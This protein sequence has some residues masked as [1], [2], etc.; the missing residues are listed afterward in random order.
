MD[1]SHSFPKPQLVY[2]SFI[3][4]TGF[5]IMKKSENLHVPFGYHC[6]NT[7]L[8]V[9]VMYVVYMMILEAGDLEYFSLWVNHM[10]PGV[11]PASFFG[12]STRISY[13]FPGSRNSSIP[14][15]KILSC[16]KATNAKE[17]PS[18]IQLLSLSSSTYWIDYTPVIQNNL[19][20]PMPSYSQ[21]GFHLKLILF[22]WHIYRFWRL[23]SVK[24][25]GTSYW[26]ELV[27]NYR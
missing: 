2:S 26:W 18:L 12:V 14:G 23:G 15:K 5:V 17:S 4:L 1:R 9:E 8:V 27:E 10:M 6:C 22:D 19:Q 21:L 11:L 7:S 20:A 24:R 3:N 13:I 25:K 16:F